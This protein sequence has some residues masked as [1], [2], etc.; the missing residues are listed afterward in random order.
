M[1]VL[2]DG[3]LRGLT[4][5]FRPKTLRGYVTL[6]EDL[7]P[8]IEEIAARLTTFCDLMTYNVSYVVNFAVKMVKKIDK[9]KR[10]DDAEFLNVANSVFKT[11]LKTPAKTSLALL[12]KIS[13]RQP[14]LIT[15]ITRA[16]VPA[17][18][19]PEA[20]V[21]STAAEML[22]TFQD[23]L[24]KATLEA[25][26]SLLE[27][28]PAAVKPTIVKLLSNTGESVEV[29]SE[30]ISEQ[31]LDEQRTECR[32]RAEELDPQ[33]RKMAGVDNALRTQ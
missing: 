5:G 33:W 18:E 31:D 22:T 10:L 14:E 16:L 9:E 11:T 30:M 32:K 23:H 27:H 6:F 29:S 12:A 15:Q 8:T 21:Q 7:E 1:I 3:C 13:K 17:L 4:F 20:E 24:E 25:L 19:H 26:G 2:L 28:L